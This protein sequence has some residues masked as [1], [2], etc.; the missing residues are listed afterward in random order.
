MIKEMPCILYHAQTNWTY[1]Q[2]L[3]TSTLDTSISLKSDND[4][5]HAV[6]SFN[7]RVQQAACIATQM[8]CNLETS[9]EYSSLTKD[10]LAE[11]RKL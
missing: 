9:F 8:C 11:K 3:I 4:I 2:E 1:F 7:H 5:V 10:Q 6:E